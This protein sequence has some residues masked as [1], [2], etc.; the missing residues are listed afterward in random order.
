MSLTLRQLEV[1]RA[2]AAE[3]HFARAADR[4][5]LSQPTVS[6]ELARLERRLGLELF[7][8][9]S[10]GTALTPEGAALLPQAERVLDALDD[11]DRAATLAR[12]RRTH[13]VRVAASPSVVN[14]V[15][16]LLLRRLE[17]SHPE[18]EVTAVEVDTGGVTAALDAATADLGLGHHVSAPARG[19][20]RTISHDELFVIAADSVVGAQGG[21][22]DLARLVDLPLL[23]WPREQSPVYHDALLE[24]CRV[25]GLDPLLL[26]GRSRLSGSRSYLLRDGRAFALGPRDFAV[27][28]GLGVRAAPLDPAAYVP[29]DLA[30][31]DP[32]SPVARIVAAEV[33]AVARAGEAPPHP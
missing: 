9:S 25:R 31:V 10:G 17:R 29:L 6:K 20:V 16:P 5:G 1:F 30:W 22:I 18:V 15:M 7:H 27:S 14:R 2:L 13:E 33:R 23:L 4:T 24:I 8:R 19:R 11:L 26:T 21:A 3:L 28:E 12:R 32:L